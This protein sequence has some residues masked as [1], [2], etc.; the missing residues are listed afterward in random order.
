LFSPT[1]T[2]PSEAEYAVWREQRQSTS[3]LVTEHQRA[4]RCYQCVDQQTH[5]AVFGPQHILFQDDRLFAALAGDPR[6]PGHT[7]VVWREHVQDFTG[8]DD[9]DTAHLF[10]VCTRLAHA[11]RAALTGVARVY[12]VSMCDG[13]VNHLHVQLIP[14]YEHEPIGSRR[15]VSPRQ[16]LRQGAEIM[17]SIRNHLAEHK[18]SPGRTGTGTGTG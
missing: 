12:L 7:V 10:S 14:R 4:G 3:D 1:F 5:G 18:P 13:P 11:I 17:T 6:S 16:P 9:P 8:L 15:F 2:P